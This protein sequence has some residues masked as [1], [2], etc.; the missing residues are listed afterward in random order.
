[1]ISHCTTYD[2]AYNITL[3]PWCFAQKAVARGFFESVFGH[4]WF[5]CSSSSLSASYVL[6]VFLSPYLCSSHFL[7]CNLLVME[8]LCPSRPVHRRK[9]G[10][11]QI[12]PIS[13][14]PTSLWSESERTSNRASL[15]ILHSC[16][17]VSWLL[18]RLMQNAG[19]F[20]RKCCAGGHN[21][22][23]VCYIASPVG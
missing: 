18:C 22:P 12:T 20:V 11:K 7:F 23:P 3:S 14:R 1:M 5:S 6:F 13:S 17:I 4:I 9:R 2:I 8:Q 21:V 19:F 15:E 10:A 16:S